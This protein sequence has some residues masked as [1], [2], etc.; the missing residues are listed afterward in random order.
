M[1]GPLAVYAG[2]G[3]GTQVAARATPAGAI[4]MPRIIPTAPARRCG[5]R[6]CNRRLSSRPPRRAQVYAAS[7]DCDPDAAYDPTRPCQPLPRAP[8]SDAPVSAAPMPPAPERVVAESLPQR[9]PVRRSRVPAAGGGPFKRPWPCLWPSRRPT[10]GTL[11]NP[12][13]RLRQPVDGGGRRGKCAFCASRTAANREDRTPRDGAA[14][15]PDRLPR[16]TVRS[17][18]FGG[19]RRLFAPQ[20]PGH[21]LHYRPAGAQFILT[22]PRE[23]PSDALIRPARARAG[24]VGCA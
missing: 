2:S 23:T 18:P 3:Q 22:G 9:M 17:V 21:R 7:A 12:G 4:R 14:G 11:G 24:H 1:S 15:N 6:S 5:R 16:A 8:M 19:G 10:A 13:R 20:R